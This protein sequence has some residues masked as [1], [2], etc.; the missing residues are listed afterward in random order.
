MNDARNAALDVLA[1]VDAGCPVQEALA[2]Y[3]HDLEARDQALLHELALGVL[4][5]S[6]RLDVVLDHYLKRPDTLPHG[7]RRILN[8]GLY[9]LLFLERI[10]PH[11]A[12]STAVETTRKRFGAK[13]ASVVNAVLRQALNDRTDLL[14]PGY[15]VRKDEPATVRTVH[16]LARYFSLPTWLF[17]S[18][19]ET[20]GTGDA[21]ALAKRSFVKPGIGLLFQKNIEL[22]TGDDCRQVSPTGVV[23]SPEAF[24]LFSQN[25]DVKK[26]HRDGT[27]SYLAGGTQAVL[28]HLGLTE[29]DGPFWDMCAGFGGKSGYLENLGIPVSLCTDTS[30]KRLS[31]LAGDFSRRRLPLPVR[32]LADGSKPPLDHFHGSILLDAPCSSLGILSRRPDIKQN[33]QKKR[34]LRLFPPQQRA[35]LLAGLSLLQKGRRL[36]YITCTLNPLENGTLIRETLAGT[37]FELEYEWQTPNTEYILEGMYCALLRR[38]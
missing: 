34:S 20:Y 11:A 8:I 38:L 26:L 35:L 28:S 37:N 10:P 32:V 2:S 22:P 33:R 1:R 3:P 27:I 21:I 30:W 13:L 7:M 9:S 19:I 18:W 25:H 29:E 24:R 36:A 16:A 6:L 15:Y 5:T 12:V 17:N 23:L 14:D 31:Q 4:R